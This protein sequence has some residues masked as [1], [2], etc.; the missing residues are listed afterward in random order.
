M[1]EYA[2][3]RDVRQAREQAQQAWVA[4]DYSTYLKIME[5]YVEELDP[6]EVRKV[7]YARKQR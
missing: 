6:S 2:R 3:R 4:K 5:P 1:D 7:D